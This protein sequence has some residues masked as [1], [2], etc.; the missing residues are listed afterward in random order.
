MT[1]KAEA[2]KQLVVVYST[3]DKLYKKGIIHR[4][5]AANQK[6]KLARFVNNLK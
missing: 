5:K 1:D 3:L 2:E 6:S 4:N